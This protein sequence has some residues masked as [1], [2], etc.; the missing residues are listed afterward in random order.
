[1]WHLLEQ[2]YKAH[3]RKTKHRETKTPYTFL[4]LLSDS[5]GLIR[6]KEGHRNLY[7]EFSSMYATCYSKHIQPIFQKSSPVKDQHTSLY[8]LAISTRAVIGLAKE[9]RSHRTFH[10][11]FCGDTTLAAHIVESRP[12]K[13][14]KNITIEETPT[15]MKR[16]EKAV[17]PQNKWTLPLLSTHLDVVTPFPKCED[18]MLQRK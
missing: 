8:I 4:H 5:L 9:K 13:T 1:M 15:D 11:K 18:R 16:T 2:Q 12:S 10:N 14:T 6:E 17:T 3:I 7:S